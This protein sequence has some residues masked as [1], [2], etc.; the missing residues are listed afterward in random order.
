MTEEIASDPEDRVTEN[1]HSEQG[2]KILEG[3]K[4]Q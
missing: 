2:D 3:Q 1:I 4:L